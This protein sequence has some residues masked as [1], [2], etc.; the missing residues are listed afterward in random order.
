MGRSATPRTNEIHRVPHE[1]RLHQQPQSS[2]CSSL[3]FL[4]LQLRA[5]RYNSPQLRVRPAQLRRQ[6]HPTLIR[7]RAIDQRRVRFTLRRNS[8]CLCRSRRKMHLPTRI[9]HPPPKKLQQFTITVHHQ[10]RRIRISESLALLTQRA[11]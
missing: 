2:R 8:P 7:Q 9:R 1:I 3:L 10:H 6:F 11:M 4:R 5:G